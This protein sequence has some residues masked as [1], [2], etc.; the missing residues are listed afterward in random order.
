MNSHLPI[1]VYLSNFLN[2]H[3]FLRI[4][5][6][7]PSTFVKYPPLYL[8]HGGSILPPSILHLHHIHS[9]FSIP[10]TSE[11]QHITQLGDDPPPPQTGADPG[12]LKGGG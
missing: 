12:F 10:S 2:I 8:N 3:T 5:T 9:A 7:F 6:S 4:H 11:L 1:P